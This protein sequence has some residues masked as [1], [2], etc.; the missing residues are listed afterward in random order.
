M[1]GK[2]L[3]YL[4]GIE[5]IYGVILAKARGTNLTGTLIRYVPGF[6]KSRHVFSYV[7]KEPRNN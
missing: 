7:L 6:T 1:F 5:E 2:T 3:I 4:F